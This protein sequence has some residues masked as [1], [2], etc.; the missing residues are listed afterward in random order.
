MSV[1]IVNK[2]KD[3]RLDQFTMKCVHPYFYL[4]S[5]WIVLSSQM[6]P[7]RSETNVC[8]Q[9]IEPLTWLTYVVNFHTIGLLPIRVP[10]IWKKA[11]V[12]PVHKKGPTTVV[13]NN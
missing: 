9:S 6:T 13:S 4:F 10:S 7:F 3:Y 5:Q 11:V 12:T 2:K 8:T 1:S